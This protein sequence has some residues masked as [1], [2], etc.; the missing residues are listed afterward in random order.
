[1]A[2]AA[3]LNTVPPIA[4]LLFTANVLWAMMYDS[5]YAMVDRQYDK[6]AGIKSTA[7]LFEGS[8]HGFIG[9][10]QVLILLTLYLNGKQLELGVFYYLSLAAAAILFAY[11]HY[12]IRDSEP[13]SCF[14]A[15][16]N[17]NWVG[18]V[19]FFGIVL[20]YYR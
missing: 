7:I 9:I 5:I 15:F 6:Q 20:D 18:A 3:T 1:M 10:F 4:W 13:G 17:N 12:L 11:Q 19:V 16:L 14:R 8:D 2:F